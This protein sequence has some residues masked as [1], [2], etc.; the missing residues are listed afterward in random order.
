[1]EI[2]KEFKHIFEAVNNELQHKTETIEDLWRLNEDQYKK[3][4]KLEKENKML[5]D[6]LNELSQHYKELL[7][8]NKNGKEKKN[9]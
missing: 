5:R 4:Q 1:M 3:I 8:Q 7:K 6:D 2:M 9:T